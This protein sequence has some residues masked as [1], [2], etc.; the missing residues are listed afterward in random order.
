MRRLRKHVIALLAAVTVAA[1]SLVA[2]PQ[3]SAMV[4]CNHRIA[5]SWTYI[6]V[7]DAVLCRRQLH[8]GPSLV[9]EGR[10]HR[11][12]LLLGNAADGDD[13]RGRAQTAP[14]TDQ[15][16]CGAGPEV[17][18]SPSAKSPVRRCR[19]RRSRRRTRDSPTRARCSTSRSG[20]TPSSSRS[21]GKV[22]GH[23]PRSDRQPSRRGSR[24][25]RGR[26]CAAGQYRQRECCSRC[27]SWSSRVRSTTSPR[28][29]RICWTWRTTSQSI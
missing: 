16:R 2:T 22:G 18:A 5:L 10:H 19:R 25:Q 15:R 27:R 17:P 26:Y 14:Q 1:T 8:D 21:A 20:S 28:C 9:R 24:P 6:G 23:A 4:N 13:P 7:G 3:A 29:P 11:L 12:R